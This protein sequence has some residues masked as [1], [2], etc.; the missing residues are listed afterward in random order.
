MDDY[1][2]GEETSENCEIKM[3]K[4]ILED[5]SKNKNIDLVIGADLSN[6]IGITNE[7]MSNFN[8]PYFGIYN[9]CASYVE[10]L[11]LSCA[12]LNGSNLKNIVT[13]VSSHALDAERTFR[14]PIEYGSPRKITQSFTATAAVG[15]FVTKDITPISIESCTIGKVVNYGIKD[16][17]NMGAIMAPGAADTLITHL[18]ELK[19]EINY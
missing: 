1:F 14:Y 7:T 15:T 16:V 3:E 4:T 5:L 6:Q 13:L 12:M 18:K 2:S 10:G 19:R 11:I 17:N 8:Y 9:A